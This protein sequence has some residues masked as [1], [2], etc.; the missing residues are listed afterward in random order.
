[1][2]PLTAESVGQKTV[3]PPSMFSSKVGRAF[4]ALSRSAKALQPCLDMIEIRLMA[5]GAEV[6][7]SASAELKVPA[8]APVA[9]KTEETK[10][11]DVFESGY[12]EVFVKERL[13]SGIVDSENGDG[14][15]AVDLIGEVSD[16]EV[17]VEG[18]EVR[19]VV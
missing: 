12:G 3:N 6:G 2:K 15:A 9:W 4:E 16:R 10:G 7:A 11:E 19:V 13:H 14:A 18:G 5:L 8:A 17:V 1:M